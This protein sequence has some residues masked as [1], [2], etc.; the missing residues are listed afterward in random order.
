MAEHHRVERAADML[1]WE[2]IGY[3]ETDG[4]A[5]GHQEAEWLYLGDDE[6]RSL[7]SDFGYLFVKDS[8]LWF[9]VA[10]LGLTREEGQAIAGWLLLAN[11]HNFSLA[12]RMARDPEKAYEWLRARK[13]SRKGLEKKFRKFAEGLPSHHDWSARRPDAVLAELGAWHCQ[14]ETEMMELGVR[15][16]W[17][18]GATYHAH[19]V[20]ML[21]HG[22]QLWFVPS[23]EGLVAAFRDTY[24]P[25]WSEV[26]L[27]QNKAAE[28]LLGRL[29]RQAK[30]ALQKESYWE[31]AEQY[32]AATGY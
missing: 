12:G 31:Q 10:T 4:G 32:W 17:C 3:V 13:P 11:R 23:E 2:H 28:D 1:K 20:R 14:N 30:V 22:A 16:G 25:R 15:F 18:F 21:N 26:R 24:P 9:D 8:N 7:V 19:Y 29:E 6:P 5:V 27:P